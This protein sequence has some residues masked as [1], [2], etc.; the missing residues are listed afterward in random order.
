MAPLEGSS[1]RACPPAAASLWL[2]SLISLVMSERD[3]AYF[4]CWFSWESACLPQNGHLM[5]TSKGQKHHQSQIRAGHGASCRF[6]LALQ[7]NHLVMCRL[8]S[9]KTGMLLSQEERC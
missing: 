2:P 5:A 4:L 1:N 6:H 7:G 3:A 9:T 8:G